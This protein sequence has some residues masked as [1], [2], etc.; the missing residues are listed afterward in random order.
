MKFV[1]ARWSFP[2]LRHAEEQVLQVVFLRPHLGQDDVVPP[3]DL[4]PL[5][6]VRIAGD[7]AWRF[8]HGSSVPLPVPVDGH[9]AAVFDGGT[10][11]GVGS[12]VDGRLQPDKVLPPGRVTP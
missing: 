9:R 8:V 2:L 4:L 1:L 12:V 5:P 7:D 11:L 10:L 3:G 6:R